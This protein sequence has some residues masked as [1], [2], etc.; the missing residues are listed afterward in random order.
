MKLIICIFVICF[1]F[2]LFITSELYLHFIYDTLNDRGF[3]D[4]Y[5]D[6]K[7]LTN[8]S[9]HLNV[10]DAS[11]YVII[12]YTKND[13]GYIDII[14]NYGNSKGISLNNI[15]YTYDNVDLSLDIPLSS[16]Q[17]LT[18]EL[19]ITI[20]PSTPYNQ[21]IPKNLFITGEE[22]LSKTFIYNIRHNQA[23]NSEYKL[24]FM[25]G[26]E[27]L[28]F[29]QTYFHPRIVEAYNDLTI[30]AYKA[31]LWRYCIVY[32]Y[33]GIYI[34]HKLN[35]FIPFNQIIDSNSDLF[36]VKYNKISKFW[37]GIF[38]SIPRH[39]FIARVIK[40]TVL[41]IEKRNYGVD[42]HD[43][44]GPRVMCKNYHNEDAAVTTTAVMHNMYEIMYK[45]KI[46]GYTST[47]GYGW[48]IKA[49][50]YQFKYLTHEVFNDDIKKHLD[51]NFN[52]LSDKNK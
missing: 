48:G 9:Y 1:F 28:E 31:D 42:A 33:G 35:M 40:N 3:I 14:R 25:N 13:K 46:V 21:H 22:P 52:I 39:P 38:G 11:K 27:R 41:N 49:F 19:P 2:F 20:R 15:E 47:I 50:R 8:F 51:H 37:N 44:T 24:H 4:D 7:G 18:L 30:G 23:L 32:L 26:K 5:P 43:I 34:D 17:Q 16:K 45:N 10:F 6:K 12:P 29:L 36:I